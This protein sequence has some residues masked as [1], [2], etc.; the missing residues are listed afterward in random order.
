MHMV[1]VV[2][3]AQGA[4]G[5]TL[6][7]GGPPASLTLSPGPWGEALPEGLGTQAVMP[8]AIFCPH[9]VEPSQ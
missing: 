1:A 7:R 6:L 4:S 3:P 5:T 9:T 8:T 2:T